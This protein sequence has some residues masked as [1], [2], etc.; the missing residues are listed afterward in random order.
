MGRR[1][2]SARLVAQVQRETESNFYGDT[3]DLLVDTVTSLGAHGNPSVTTT[4]TAISCSFTDKPDMENWKDFAD[5]TQI[6]AEIRFATPAPVNGN[7]ITLKG[8][9][10]GTAFADKTFE[11]IS[12]RDRD[13]FGFLCALKVIEL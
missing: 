13:A 4:T 10:D 5:I 8:Q 1:L 6:S 2:A 9:Y 3:A 11:I 7:R 12:I